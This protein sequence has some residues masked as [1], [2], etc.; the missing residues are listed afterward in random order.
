MKRLANTDL[1]FATSY[2]SINKIALKILD[3]AQNIKKKSETEK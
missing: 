1:I 3:D 2:L